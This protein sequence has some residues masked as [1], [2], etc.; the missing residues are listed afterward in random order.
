MHDDTAPETAFVEG[1]TVADGLRQV[2]EDNP[3]DGIGV[4][5]KVYLVAS[6]GVVTPKP[7]VVVPLPFPTVFETQGK[8]EPG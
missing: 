3:K 7:P 8:N 4:I 5:L 2:R 1:L 6:L